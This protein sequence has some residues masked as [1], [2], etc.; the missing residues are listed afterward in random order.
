MSASEENTIA[1]YGVAPGDGMQVSSVLIVG[2]RTYLT[3]RW[4]EPTGRVVEYEVTVTNVL[5]VGSWNRVDIL[6]YVGRE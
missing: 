1:S 2:H 6:H 5:N 4:L 3:L